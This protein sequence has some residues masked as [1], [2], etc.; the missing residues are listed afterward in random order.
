MANSTAFQSLSDS[1][2]RKGIVA[3][4][5]LAL[6]AQVQSLID[7]LRA[8][9]TQVVH[10]SAK[11][12][13]VPPLS[14]F[15]STRELFS[16]IQLW[17]ERS[18]H[19]TLKIID[20][21]AIGP[22]AN[23]SVLQESHIKTIELHEHAAKEIFDLV[24]SLLDR[25]VIMLNR[26]LDAFSTQLAQV[27][28]DIIRPELEDQLEYERMLVGRLVEQKQVLEREKD[29]LQRSHETLAAR[30]DLIENA[31]DGRGD[32]ILCNKL[33]TRVRDLE[34]SG[35]DL[36]SRVESLTIERDKAKWEITQVQRHLEEARKT[37]SFTCAM[38][39]KETKQLLTVAQMNYEE[40]NQ[41]M[42]ASSPTLLSFLSDSFAKYDTL[43]GRTVVHSTPGAS[44]NGT[45]APHSPTKTRL[46]SMKA[47]KAPCSPNQQS[48]Q[49]AT[50][51]GSC[52]APTP[53]QAH[54][55]ESP[56][57][58]PRGEIVRPFASR[59]SSDPNYSV[60]AKQQSNT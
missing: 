22:T 56:I 18:L 59:Y 53:P 23:A 36:K 9:C 58:S 50:K 14:S 41:V 15:G 44:S 19:Q 24:Q 29:E 37:L 48:R 6:P 43:S 20:E 49:L 57:S 34:A 25:A 39:E 33:R 1:F 3:G 28:D 7:S 42:Q 46:V 30:L 52:V 8:N 10:A 4:T 60:D 11:S 12:A 38:H 35:R 32:A 21:A 40:I 27:L 16:G 31:P 5:G 13:L 45:R 54:T 51:T 2:Q 26:Q 47:S 17:K 55:A